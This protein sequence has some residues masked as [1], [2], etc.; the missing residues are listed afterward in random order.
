M[1]I[2]NARKKIL[3]SQSVYTTSE[4]EREKKLHTIASKAL[5]E[6]RKIMIK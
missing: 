6:V 2:H 4:T 5:F 3:H 1:S